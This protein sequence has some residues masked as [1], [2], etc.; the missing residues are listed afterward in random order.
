MSTKFYIGW[1]IG[2]A[3]LKVCV[4]DV[5]G[6]V[7]YVEQ[8]Y[9]PLW[10]GIDCL[11]AGLRSLPSGY[12]EGALHGVTM[13]GE[14]ADCFADRDEGVRELIDLFCSVYPAEQ[15]QI[16]AGKRGW[17]KSDDVFG[18]EAAIASMNW[19]ATGAFVARSFSDGIFIDVGSTT[20]DLIPIFNQIPAVAGETDYTRMRSEELIYMGVIRTPIAMLIQRIPFRGEAV[21]I[22]REHFATMADVYRL[23]GDLIDDAL[24]R[25]EES[26]DG[27]GWDALAC[28]R[29]IARLVG[30]DQTDA[31]MEEWREV[32]SA[33]AAHQLEILRAGF[34]RVS[35]ASYHQRQREKHNVVIAAGTGHF[36]IRK[37][38]QA[39]NLT[40]YD[41]TEL[42][43]AT[44]PA[45]RRLAA[46][47]A[48]ATACASLLRTE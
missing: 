18:N 40:Y 29:R 19:H 44:S 31:S 13:T 36:L 4:T 5:Q 43:H 11:I 28:S 17:L 15:T 8:I 38:A 42:I 25:E 22:A 10:R 33:I 9:T 34:K 23:T 32:A 45:L 12:Q 3:H 2:G 7:I 20:T 16:Y 41:L 47:C 21:Q 26:A 30:C 27:L 1:D 6:K 37:L 24:L 35:D 14:L 48:P 39:E 46:I